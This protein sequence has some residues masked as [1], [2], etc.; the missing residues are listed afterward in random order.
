VEEVAR[1]IGKITK[2]SPDPIKRE[3]LRLADKVTEA[4]LSAQD[5]ALEE[6]SDKIAKRPRRAE[7]EEGE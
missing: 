2:R 6:M 7:S 4:D 1:S 3:F 5:A